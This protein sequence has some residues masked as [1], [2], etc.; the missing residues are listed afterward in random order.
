[1]KAKRD[2]LTITPITVSVHRRGDDPHSD[3]AI[4]VSV[5]GDHDGNA[6][7]RIMPRT[8]DTGELLLSFQEL[9]MVRNAALDLV[10]RYND[11]AEVRK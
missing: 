8:S 3:A 1:M 6:Q 4:L 11:N 5:E 7:L 10:A 9:T 2:Y